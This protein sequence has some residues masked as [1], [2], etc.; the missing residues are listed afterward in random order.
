MKWLLAVFIQTALITLILTSQIS[1][2][3]QHGLIILSLIAHAWLAELFP[4]SVTALLVPVLAVAFNVMDLKVALLSF[5]HPIIFLFLGGFALAATLHE[6]KLDQHFAHI[7]MLKAKNNGLVICL[8]LFSL[9]AFLSMWISNTATTVMMLPIALGLMS[10]LEYEKH[11]TVFAFLLLGIAYSANIG[12]IATI[13]GSPP[14]AIAASA[15]GLSFYEWLIIAL[16]ISLV[17]L[18][19][20][21]GILYTYLKPNLTLFKSEIAEVQSFAWSRQRIL[22]IIIFITTASLW[23]FG[24]FIQGILG[25]IADFDSWIAIIAIVVLHASKS[26]SWKAFEN[27]TQWGVLLLFGGGL[28]LSAVL[29]ATGANLYLAQ[30]LEMLSAGLSLY[31]LLLLV[32]LFIIFM[33]EISSN[34]ALSALMIPTFMGMADVM[35]LDTTMIVSAI[36]I[37]ASCAFILPVATPPNAIVFSSG[38]IPQNTMMKVGLILNLIFSMIITSYMFWL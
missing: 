24:D 15:L 29:S 3:V 19:L 6:H 21:W 8:I 2:S 30:Q 10:H 33:T 4:L 18:P 17:L 9:T 35:G 27:N 32:I 25:K 20:M 23:I 26:L 11:K 34:T 37:A 13:V 36:A 12:G 14:N 22:A 7:L 5:A 1:E 28:A 38:Y 16:P 31:W